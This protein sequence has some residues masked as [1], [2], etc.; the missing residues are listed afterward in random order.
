M[1]MEIVL[2][3]Q[4]QLAVYYRNGTKLQPDL[5][6]GVERLVIIH[7]ATIIDFGVEDV[8]V[9]C[10]RFTSD[11]QFSNGIGL[12]LPP[13]HSIFEL[14]QPFPFRQLD[15]LDFFRCNRPGYSRS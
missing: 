2:M 8:Q 9:F 14:A 5:D 7:P 6:I 15:L 4:I 3:S 11:T 10:N 13:R 12:V 1:E